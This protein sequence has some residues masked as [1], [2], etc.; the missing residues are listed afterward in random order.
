M[1]VSYALRGT[2]S[3]QL[4]QEDE[5]LCYQLHTIITDYRIAHRLLPAE[6]VLDKIG[7]G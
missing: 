5:A 7:H 4:K 3:M 1:T 6:E 2:S